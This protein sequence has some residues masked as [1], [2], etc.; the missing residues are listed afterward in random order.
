MNPKPITTPTP[1][2]SPV[3]TSSPSKDDEFVLTT[4]MS[5]SPS[6]DDDIVVVRTNPTNPNKK[7]SKPSD[8]FKNDFKLSDQINY[9]KKFNV[10]IP[11]I[12]RGEMF[13]NTTSSDLHNHAVLLLNQLPITDALT[14]IH[15]AIKI[16]WTRMV[17]RSYRDGNEVDSIVKRLTDHQKNNI[18]GQIYLI[19]IP[20]ITLTIK[21]D[22]GIYD[23]KGELV[24][25]IPDINYF[26]ILL[27][28]IE[29]LRSAQFN[30]TSCDKLRDL[31]QT[32][33]GQKLEAVFKYSK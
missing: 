29:E 14:V 22:H 28:T 1:V 7:R 13:S 32:L 3:S 17:K 9:K 12:M 30:S 11:I 25:S 15:R 21:D 31:F 18:E 24:L 4:T 27:L 6:K 33:F 26:P 5:S 8:S 2:T 23:I 10:K 16:T 20:G 19:R